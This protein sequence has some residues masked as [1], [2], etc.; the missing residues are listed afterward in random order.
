MKPPQSEF[1][2]DAPVG[3]GTTAHV[4]HVLA[5]LQATSAELP[6]PGGVTDQKIK[7]RGLMYLF[8]QSEFRIYKKFWDVVASP[9]ISSRDEGVYYT[10]WKI[11]DF[12]ITQI[13]REINFG[14]D[15]QMI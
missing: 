14:A 12:S 13:L 15:F 8:L 6:G 9:N 7:V 1:W 3:S 5:R 4:A 2:S 11:H 10:V